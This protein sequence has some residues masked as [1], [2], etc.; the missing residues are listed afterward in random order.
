MNVI[1]KDHFVAVPEQLNSATVR[2]DQ[3]DA[4]IRTLLD[5]INT[6]L[7][8]KVPHNLVNR[9]NKLDKPELIPVSVA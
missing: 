2:L 1:V 9:N 8:I 4:S 5:D 6:T 7:S 3:E